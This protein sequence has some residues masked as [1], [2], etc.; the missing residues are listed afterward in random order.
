MADGND[1]IRGGGEAGAR[2][3]STNWLTLVTAIAGSIAAVGTVGLFFVAVQSLAPIIENF[4]LEAENQRLTFK[5]DELTQRNKAVLR[6]NETSQAELASLN[7]L[8]TVAREE[9]VANR[10]LQTDV[11]ATLTAVTASLS[12]ERRELDQLRSA[13]NKTRED[14]QALLTDNTELEQRRIVA[15]RKAEEAREAL[16]SVEKERDVALRLGRQFIL[17]QLTATARA[18]FSVPGDV[19][20]AI[21][22]IILNYDHTGI[23]SVK[24]GLLF[25]RM[26]SELSY[27]STDMIKGFWAAPNYSVSKGLYSEPIISLEKKSGRNFIEDHMGDDVFDILP[28]SHRARLQRDIREYLDANKSIFS[29]LISAGVEEADKVAKLSEPFSQSM[30]C[31]DD[32]T[33]RKLLEKYCAQYDLDDEH[34]LK[35]EQQL[36]E[37]RRK[38]I[39]QLTSAFAARAVFHVALGKMERDLMAQN[40]AP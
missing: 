17:R 10:Q 37:A 4:Q 5:N 9:L 2:S 36:A 31:A 8:N 32:S 1:E 29:S 26:S 7:R 39:D 18:A 38:L 27:F 34:L 12:S 3:S 28:P 23:F 11:I 20:V 19:D 15:Q 21:Q 24:S 33:I 35:L 6:D 30:A 22:R 40:E 25:G 13:A 14:N 16:V